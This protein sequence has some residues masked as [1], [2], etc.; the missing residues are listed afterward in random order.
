[1]DIADEWLLADSAWWGSGRWFGRCALRL[2]HGVPAGSGPVA[3]EAVPAGA[4]IRQLDGF[5]LPGLRDA[6][7][8]CGLVDLRSVRAGGIAEV[9]DLG[10]A[11]GALEA[12]L[13]AD[14]PALPRMQVVGAFLT[15]PRGYPSDRSW[16]DAGSFRE[17]RSPLDAAAAVGEQQQV[18]ARAIKV[19]LN[20]AA[21]PVL[22]ASVLAAIVTAAHDAGLGVIAHV[23]GE[24]MTR[25]AC[26]NGIERL[27]H[28]PWTER[29]DDR[30]LADVA[31]GMSWVST[32]DI[33]GFGA[34]TPQLRTATDNLRRFVEHG[35]VVHYG[36]DLGNGPLPLGVNPREVNALLAVGLTPEDVLTAMTD[37]RSPC[38]PCWV[39]GA[40]DLTPARFADSLSR[41]QVA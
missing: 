27:A 13:P 4:R 32:L 14:D 7:V 28:T 25:F 22:P 11:P 40:L 26:D 3:P 6:H 17:V 21:G 16:A 31:Q 33:H 10:S 2:H 30:L 37:V 34:D 1:M 29:V 36:T 20:S 15:A 24:G 12:H 41:V 38:P 39:P 35:G 9:H 19:A 5:V 8:H 18:G 23:E